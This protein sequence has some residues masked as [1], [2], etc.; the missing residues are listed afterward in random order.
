MLCQAKQGT[1]WSMS[2]TKASTAKLTAARHAEEPTL[3]WISTR[4]RRALK[5]NRAA[6]IENPRSSSIFKLSPLRSIADNENFAFTVTDQCRY[7]ALDEASGLPVK[8]STSFLYGGLSLER[9]ALKCSGEEKCATHAQLQ[10]RIPG[11]SINRTAAAA[12]YPWPLTAALTYD[13]AS[14]T[15]RAPH[16]LCTS[17]W[18]CERCRHGLHKKLVDGSS[19]PTGDHTRARGCRLNTS[20]TVDVP[21]GGVPAA[22]AAD[23]PVGGAEPAAVPFLPPPAA[24]AL[25]PPPPGPPPPSGLGLG[26]AQ[27][28]PPQAPMAACSV[29]PTSAC[30][31][32]IKHECQHAVCICSAPCL[33][34][35]GT[36]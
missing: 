15:G 12:V 16:V 32:R 23:L 17:L 8:K 31:I 19:V 7:G 10:G 24:V 26:F 2:N 29:G 5:E 30:R 1:A 18:S 25:P 27:P 13:I 36:I 20:R 35:Y 9:L 33:F 22:D 6:V 3:K 21:P 34:P 28:P 4:A 11:T 14:R